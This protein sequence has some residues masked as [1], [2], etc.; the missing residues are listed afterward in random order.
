MTP[1][2]PQPFPMGPCGPRHLEV[3]SRCCRREAKELLVK[4]APAAANNTVAVNDNAL[5]VNT[6]LTVGESGTA[7]IGGGCCVELSV[8]YMP[9]D[10]TVSTQDLKVTVEVVDSE[11]CTLSWRKTF[12]EGYHVKQAIITTYPGA[13]LVVLVSGAIARVR[14]C[15]VF[16]C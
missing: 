6:G 16:S 7:I 9:A 11:G 1:Y 5:A 13:Q 2:M 8:E 15:E 3:P 4:P 14:W 10:P 12:R